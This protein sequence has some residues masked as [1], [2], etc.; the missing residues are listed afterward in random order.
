MQLLPYSAGHAV[1]SLGQFRWR[2][3]IHNRDNCFCLQKIEPPCQKCAER[4][5]TA[6]C[7]PRPVPTG[8]CYDCITQQRRTWQLHFSQWTAHRPGWPRPVENLHLQTS[9]LQSKRLICN[10]CGHQPWPLPNCCEAS[11][12]RSKQ[13]RQQGLKSIAGQS[14]NRPRTKSPNRRRGN[15]Q[16]VSGPHGCRPQKI[17]DLSSNPLKQSVCSNLFNASFVPVASAAPHRRPSPHSCSR[18]AVQQQGGSPQRLPVVTSA[19]GGVRQCP[20]GWMR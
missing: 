10:P 3:G 7:Q 20:R 9:P 19:R 11:A 2:T 18:L 4:E 17:T 5:F 6:T 16:F 13:G 14:H 1:Q 12:A 15:N 8:L